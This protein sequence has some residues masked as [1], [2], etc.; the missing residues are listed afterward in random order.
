MFRHA[1]PIA[2]IAAS[3]A[4]SCVLAF[5][6]AS[7]YESR[8]PTSNTLYAVQGTVTAVDLHAH[9]IE[10]DIV[11]VAETPE[12]RDRIRV[13]VSDDAS[14]GRSSITLRDDGSLW[15]QTAVPSTI[16]KITVGDRAFALFELSNG[17]FIASHVLYHSS[18]SPIP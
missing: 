17:S 15:Y 8:P 12:I 3:F 5:A 4:L 1:Q 14:I 13:R 16:S 6:V 7:T 11:P 10:L 18:L 2:Y 9:T